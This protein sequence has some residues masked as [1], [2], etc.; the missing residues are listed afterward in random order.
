[1]RVVYVIQELTEG[2]FIGVDGLGGLEYVRKLDEAF[3]FRNLNV[4]LDHGRDIDSSLRNV[5]F[6]SLYEPE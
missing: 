5:A 6:Y 3:R 1:M 4:A 2:A